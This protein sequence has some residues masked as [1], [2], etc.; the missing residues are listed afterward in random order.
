MGQSDVLPFSHDVDV[1]AVAD[2]LIRLDALSMEPDVTPLKLAK[3]LY[4]SQANYLAST[5]RRMFA[6]AVEAYEH[7]PVVHREWKRH[8]GRQIIA[9]HEDLAMSEEVRLPDDVADFLDQVWA[10]YKDWS[11][12]SLRALTHKQDPWKNNYYDGG[13]R[14]VI[15]DR[16]MTTYF[17]EQVAATDRIF[18]PNVV[19]M[20]E[21]FIDELDADAFAARY[22]EFTG[23]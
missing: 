23:R 4:L 17:R 21:G 7:G 2:Y 20:P 10:R 5:G 6:E 12:V 11:A 15:P 19:I 9:V 14:I 13:F 1:T 8:P 22:A 18:H 16:D 3:L